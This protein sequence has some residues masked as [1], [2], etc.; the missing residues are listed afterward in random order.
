[1]LFLS[2]DFGTS[3]IKVAV[4]ADDLAIQQTATA[5][6]PHILLPGDKNEIDPEQLWA[7]CYR[8]CQELDPDL[9][10]RVDALC[11]DTFSPS[12]VFVKPMDR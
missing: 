3:S 8:A 4:V 2:V 5:P 1:V 10:A 9:R 11:Y 12:P 6:Y 7:A